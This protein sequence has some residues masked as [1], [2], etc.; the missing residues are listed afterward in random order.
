MSKT[1]PAVITSRY[2][3]PVIYPVLFFDFLFDSPNQLYLWNGYGVITVDSKTYTGAGHIIG[4]SDVTE[5]AEIAAK[6]VTVTLSGISSA[7]ISLAL[8]EPYQGR[9]C[10]I[11][12]ALLSDKDTLPTDGELTL[13]FS[14]YMDTMNIAE[15]GDTCTIDLGV[16]NKLVDLERPRTARYTNAYQQKRFPSDLGL[17][18][19]D[20]IQNRVTFWGKSDTGT[21]SGV[22]ETTPSDSVFGGL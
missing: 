18:F 7:I 14:G 2:D 15:S 10:N 21:S 12:L 20:D 13:I 6:G 16:E 19:I 3:D 22:V 4:I 8:S 17:E 11:Y 1:L 5:S 9:V